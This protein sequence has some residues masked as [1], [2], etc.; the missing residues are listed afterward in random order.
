M[1]FYN[2][3]IRE[4]TGEEL[5]KLFLFFI[6]S[7]FSTGVFSQYESENNFSETYQEDTFYQQGNYGQ[8]SSP[9]VAN[10]TIIYPEKSYFVP[11]HVKQNE[12]TIPQ[13]APPPVLLGDDLY[14]PYQL[15]KHA[16]F[17][18]QQ[19]LNRFMSACYPGMGCA[20]RPAVICR[21]SGC[22]RLN[23]RIT[24]QFLFNSL[25][26]IFL[27]NQMT[28]VT[29]CEADPHSRA[30]LSNSIRFGG[31]VG[32]TPALIQV[33]SFTLVEMKP[34]QNLKK[35]NLFIR[36][37][38]FA[39]GLKSRCSGSLSSIEAISSQQLIMR[40]DGYKCDLTFGMPTTAFS[41]YNI[42]Y[43]DL[44]YGIIGAFYSIGLSGDST[45][46]GTGYVLMKFRQAGMVSSDSGVGGIVGEGN[47]TVSPYAEKE[48]TCEDP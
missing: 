18:H 20:I 26:K 24:K 29:L 25:I 4:T 48:E 21:R 6:L 19:D 47:Y 35:L 41:L 42:D 45:A 1:I 39:N 31:N 38:V 16:R 13:I 44:D 22:T 28:K 14:Y 46:G 3:R 7:V 40:D 9:S 27:N 43:I 15:S 33:P 2:A 32:G 12:N 10:G 5:K 17:S 37:D 34:L 23:D 36:Y 30:C 11:Y 8:N